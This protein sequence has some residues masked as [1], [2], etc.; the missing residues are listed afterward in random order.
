MATTSASV[1]IPVPPDRVWK[2]I[3]GFGSLP[4]WLPYIAG[5]ELGEGERAAEGCGGCADGSRTP[6]GARPGQPRT[7]FCA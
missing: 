2:L 4:D 5:S 1:R 7:M 6:L 3:G